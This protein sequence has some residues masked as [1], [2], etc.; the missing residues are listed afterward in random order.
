MGV[1]LGCQL[2]LDNSSENGSYEGL[3]LI[4]GK[5]RKIVPEDKLKI[6]N[7]GWSKLI[8]ENQKSHLVFK[9]I[10]NEEYFYFTHSYVCHPSNTSNIIAN[11]EYGSQ[12][13]TAA[14][15]KDNVYGFQ[16]HPE[17]SGNFGKKIYLNFVNLS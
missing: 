13:L 4:Q 2:L 12:H 5:V 8:I 17:L 14:I 1:C 7:V 16:F 15:Q 10:K 3:S 11:I 9:D 6:P